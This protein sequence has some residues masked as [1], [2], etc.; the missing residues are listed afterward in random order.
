MEYNKL[1]NAKSV[2]KV[3]ACLEER[4]Y[5]VE[6][7]KNK[8]EALELVKKVIPKGV[9]VM[10]GSSATLEQIGF[11]EY[12]K[13]G[14]HG[15]NNLHE[16]IVKEKDRDKQ[17]E[18]RRQALLSDFYL[19]SVHALVENGEFVIA[20]NS[21]SQLPHVV[22]SSDNLIFVVSTKKIVA[23]L[24]EAMKRLEEHVVPLEDKHMMDLYKIHTQVSKVVVFK[25][26]SKFSTRT[27]RFVLV[28]E[29]LGF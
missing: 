27:I 5:E 25:K 19:G 7:V 17:K 24:D 23:T 1:A 26:E 16:A 28:E 11:V 8:T 18:L 4:G 13:S 29:D 2:Q 3:T 15:W 14:K 6:V 22:Y 20:S 21:G 10:N 12:L 9:S